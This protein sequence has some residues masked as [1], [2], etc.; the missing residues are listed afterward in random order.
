MC[1]DE[2]DAPSQ[3]Q[4]EKEGLQR[5]EARTDNPGGILRHYSS[6]QGSGWESQALL[7]LNLDR[8]TRKAFIVTL[9]I[10]VRPGKWCVLSGREMG[11]LVTWDAEKPD[12]INDFFACLHWQDLQL[13]SPSPR[14][15]S[16][17]L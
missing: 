9:V 7:E 2:Y 4:A 11:D 1:K 8:D 10:K 16:Q 15:Q 6:R 3:T 14:R 5:V 17:E 12:V 13:Y